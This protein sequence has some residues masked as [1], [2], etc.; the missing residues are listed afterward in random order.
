[1][2][3]GPQAIMGMVERL[4]ALPLEVSTDPETHSDSGRLGLQLGQLAVMARLAIRAGNRIQ[5]GALGVLSEQAFRHNHRNQN[6]VGTGRA[7]VMVDLATEAIEL[8]DGLLADQD[9][10]AEAE[11][12]DLLAMAQAFLDKAEIALVAGEDGRAAHLAH[13]AEW[14][15]LKAVVLPGGITDEEAQLIFDL[16]TSLLEDAGAA[17][18]L[19]EPSDLQIAL[20]ARA[21]KM[22]ENGEANLE[23]GTCRGLGALWQSAVISSYLIG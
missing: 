12:L 8:A 11:Q 4:E 17:L 21:T 20:L 22:L 16:A 5:A 2:V 10:G 1:M 19:I 3:G 15:A 13:M 14:W 9:G 18:E 7:E 6:Q 23:N